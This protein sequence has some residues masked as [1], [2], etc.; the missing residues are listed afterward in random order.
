MARELQKWRYPEG[1]PARVTKM[2]THEPTL[3][4]KLGYAHY[5]LTVNDLVDFA[6]S[7]DILCQGR[8]LRRAIR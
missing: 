7:R 2:L 1:A 8:S 4:G 5:F 6:R 3:I